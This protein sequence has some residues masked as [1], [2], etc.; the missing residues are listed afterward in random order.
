MAR[1]FKEL[2]AKIILIPFKKQALSPF[3]CQICTYK[4]Q[5]SLQPALC[6]SVVLT[7]YFELKRNG[8]FLQKSLNVRCIGKFL[9]TPE[10]Q[11]EILGSEAISIMFYL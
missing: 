4:C 9:E 1:V 7:L 2:N 10:I 5:D 8:T 11:M 3:C 6:F